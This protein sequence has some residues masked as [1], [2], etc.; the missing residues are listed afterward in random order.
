MNKK[1]L[2]D[3]LILVIGI[4]IFSGCIGEKKVGD[5]GMGIVT[6]TILA[7]PVT[8][9]IAKA[10]TTTTTTTLPVTIT[11]ITEAITTT[12]TIIS[13]KEKPKE[14]PAEEGT[15]VFVDDFNRVVEIPKNPK[16]IVCVG[17]TADVD[18]LFAINAGDKLVGIPITKK[19][20]PEGASNLPMV[21]STNTPNFEAIIGL[22][23]DLVVV[24]TSFATAKEFVER[25]DDLGITV[26]YNNYPKTP[27]EVVKHI[28]GLGDIIGMP[29][30]ANEFADDF[31]RRM[32]AITD[33]TDKLN[34][35]EKPLVFAGKGMGES[36][37]LWAP[38][39]E[40]RE[41]RLIEM[42]GG[43]NVF[44]DLELASGKTGAYVNPEAVIEKNPEIIINLVKTP[45][46]VS[47]GEGVN[48]VRDMPG[49]KHI[50]AVKNNRVCAIEW[51]YTWAGP[52]MIQGLEEFAHCI[53][54][55]LFNETIY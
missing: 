51:Q 46:V 54:P 29:K 33:I 44:A 42:A 17:A 35:D 5:N 28:R 52:K 36:T 50:N 9:T 55:E 31:Q 25:L 43:I 10:V 18:I 49:W 34:D 21:G 26:I 30:E 8:T 45:W 41:G 48:R 38:G 2:Y 53:H 15:K 14:Q 23:S 4:V 20:L 40:S 24:T 27:E 3:V 1:R 22:N 13:E 12:T 37:T 6:T 16:R 47:S 11:T 7:P 19:K 32:D 39:K